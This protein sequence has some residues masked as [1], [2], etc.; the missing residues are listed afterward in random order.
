M[1][2]STFLQH[3]ADAMDTLKAHTGTVKCE[4]NDDGSV[5]VPLN[6]ETIAGISHSC[7]AWVYAWPVITGETLFRMVKVGILWRHV[8]T[9][10]DEKEAEAVFNSIPEEANDMGGYG[11]GG[12][13]QMFTQVCPG[14][15][16]L[17]NSGE[18]SDDRVI[19]SA[20]FSGYLEEDVR[21]EVAA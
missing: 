13:H 12:R 11:G 18:T 8:M 16:A 14:V 6:K 7:Q 5:S 20:F 4:P 19:C 3:F 10:S 17:L 21:V 9:K 1:G 2:N 15:M